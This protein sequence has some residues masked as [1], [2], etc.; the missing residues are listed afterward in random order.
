[1]TQD[2]IK[3][4]SSLPH[5][6]GPNSENHRSNIKLFHDLLPQ[7]FNELLSVN[8]RFKSVTAYPFSKLEALCKFSYHVYDPFLG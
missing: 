3:H 4:A 8:L 2:F 7:F 1:M 5:S 6:Q